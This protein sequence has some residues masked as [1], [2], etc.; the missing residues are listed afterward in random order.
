[1][2]PESLEP[3]VPD[4]SPRKSELAQA[5]TS[6]AAQL[7]KRVT[8]EKTLR[9]SPSEI[10]HNREALLAAL[11]LAMSIAISTG[12]LLGMIIHPLT[13]LLIGILTFPAS[14]AA[15]ILA[16]TS[17][18][19]RQK[20]RYSVNSLAVWGR[21]GQYL[22]GEAHVVL[23]AAQMSEKIVN[24]PVWRSE[25]LDDQRVRMNPTEEL[26]QIADR[27]ARLRQLRVDLGPSP[28]ASTTAGS[29]RA[30]YDRQV[31][32]LDLVENALVG[33]LA[34]IHLYASQLDK[35]TPL[36]DAINAVKR[37]DSVADRINELVGQ[38]VGDEMA[39]QDIT[40]LRHELSDIAESIQA[41][42]RWLG[43]P[44]AQLPLL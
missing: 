43:T 3:K 7:R 15:L 6:I 8:L 40:N 4:P 30:I 39:T 14:S 37:I 1:M 2:E 21:D 27:A 12:V 22:A 20:T 9:Q 36:L 10:L 38:S 23:L 11:V 26:A 42:L 32:A 29:I 16:P 28:S 41:V 44:P 5:R 31:A 33:R 25:W 13:G 24:H 35:L 17:Q 19:I 18:R 34:A